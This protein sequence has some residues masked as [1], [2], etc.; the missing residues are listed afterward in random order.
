MHKVG[1]RWFSEAE[2]ELGLGIICAVEGKTI[3]VDFPAATEKRRYN[4]KSAPLKRVTYSIGDTIQTQD[5]NSLE[6]TEISDHNG[7]LFYLC[8]DQVI[9]EMLLK[10]ALSFT[11]P[12]DKLF[13]GNIDSMEL[14]HLRYE[15]TL[16]MRRYQQ[17]RHKGFLGAKVSLI[18]HQMYVVNEICS[19]PTVR[20]MLADE[21]G[22]G[23]TIEAALISKSLLLQN[24][25][26]RILII[27]PDSLVYQ[28]FIEFY[29]K[30]NIRFHTISENSDLEIEVTDFGHGPH[31]IVGMS[32]V[33]ELI[34]EML[35][36]KWDLL[37]IDEAH[38]I[39]WK[40]DFES[41][42][43]IW[44]KKLAIQIPNLLLLSAT[45]EVMGREGHFARLQ[46]LDSDKFNNYQTYLN[47]QNEY[48]EL[49]PIIKKILLNE[50]TPSDLKHF[51]S[52]EE[53]SHFDNNEEIINSLIDRHGTGRIYFRN[54]RENMDKEHKFFPKRKL[55]DYPIKIE[56]KINDKIVFEHKIAHLV[57]LLQ[58]N[59]NDKVLLITHSRQLVQ[60]IAK[61]LNQ[62]STISVGAFHS[63]Q[64][65]MERD[66]QA[67]WFADP[68]GARVLLCT[69]IGSEGRNFEFANHL[70][71]F[72]IPK[73]SDQLEQRIGRLDRIGRKGD[74]LIHV[75]YV[76]NTFEELLFHWYNDVLGSFREAPKGANL[77]YQQFREN[78]HALIESA[79]DAQKVFKFLEDASL[80]YQQI[81]FELS[82]GHDLLLDLNSFNVDKS[83]KI[84]SEIVDFELNNLKDY[85][86][87][88]FDTVG[89]NI[90]ELGQHTIFYKPSDNMLLPSYPG[91]HSEGVSISYDRD[92]A[93]K[94]DDIDFMSWEHPLAI[95]SMELF[96]DT[97]IGNMNVV[98]LKTKLPFQIGFEFYFKLDAHDKLGSEV[99]HYLPITPI[100]V[101]LDESSS[102]RTQQIP[103]KRIDQL[104][105]EASNEYRQQ[106]QKMPKDHFKNLLVAATK[107]AS[108]RSTIYRQDA[109]K[110]LEHDTQQA[111]DRIEA[112]MKVNNSINS[113][114]TK[115]IKEQYQKVKKQIELAEVAIDS[116]RII[117]S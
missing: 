18:D 36:N 20:A 54:T 100:R 9:P 52:N 115:K 72:D 13:A 29:K 16:A 22:L 1:Q 50:H 59:P 17:F 82:H 28:W 6:V 5:N 56:G 90:E 105:E 30:F 67:A 21:V 79:Y 49:I 15:S 76:K 8:H 112:L 68:E 45:P 26:E 111:L 39:Q 31:Y 42:E 44:A 11:R 55:I 58:R 57:E 69:E 34:P 2:P 86:H 27:V 98:Q 113:D 70:F 81:K 107:L 99:Y 108:K 94:R 109:C 93:L 97:E 48:Q 64:S 53:I 23:K 33:Q 84:K 47:E 7:I 96:I 37:I 10:S 63:E 35:E 66:R 75:P 32:K 4:T 83:K 104:I 78:I 117:I 46:L 80:R 40:Q 101:L 114:E 41:P 38:R 89:V 65:L 110:Q 12:Q 24:K 92:F 106:I 74:I 85:L 19:R 25:V 73:V 103:K 102:D 88:V 43:Y 14:F 77:L 95:G 61:T 87:R 3:D 62:V 60:Q 91:L 71:L 116:L 51:F